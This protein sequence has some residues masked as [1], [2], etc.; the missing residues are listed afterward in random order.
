V[1]AL[2]S[3]P[4]IGL[5]ALGS[6][7]LATGFAPSFSLSPH[8][9]GVW[10][11][12]AEEFGWR[13]FALPRLQLTHS[14]FFS[15]LMVGLVWGVWHLPITSVA[16]PDLLLLLLSTMGLSVLMTWVLNNTGGSVLLAVLYQSAI[17]VTYP[18]LHL[19]GPTMALNVGFLWVAVLMVIVAFGPSRLSR[20]E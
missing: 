13:G 14:A 19:R 10:S 16:V 18:M 11:G 15:S 20:K 4:A 12:L 5:L 7:A 3:A 8:L 2:L 9:G 6:H 17:N 1:F